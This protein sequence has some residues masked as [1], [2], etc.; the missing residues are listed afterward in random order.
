VGGGVGGGR[1]GWWG[2]GVAGGERGGGGPYDSS[3]K[4]YC[5]DER[6]RWEDFGKI[7]LIDL[8]R[9]KRERKGRGGVVYIKKNTKKNDQNNFTGLFKIERGGNRLVP[10]RR[11]T[12]VLAFLAV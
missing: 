10:N 7:L 12:V 9:M 8:V 1:G 4:L 2:G 11:A 3:L 6:V 5:I